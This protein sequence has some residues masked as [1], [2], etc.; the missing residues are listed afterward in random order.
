MRA[1]RVDDR[2]VIAPA[3]THR[4]R[5]VTIEPI[6]HV[7]ESRNIIACGIE[8]STFVQQPTQPT[9]HRSVVVDRA[10]VVNGGHESFVGDVQQRHARRLID[11]PA[12]GFDDAVLDLV[13]GAEA[14]PATDAIG[15]VDQIDE[16]PELDAV[17]RYGPASANSTDTISGSIATCASQ[18]RT[19]MSGSTRSIPSCKNSRLFAS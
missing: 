16:R 6:Q 15:L 3:Q 10:F 4:D 17:D 2:V 14:V 9:T 5:A 7:S 11:T 18:W 8:P 13:T 12:L 1:G 19:P